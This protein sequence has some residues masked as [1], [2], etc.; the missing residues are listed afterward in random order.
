MQIKESELVEW[1]FM[2]N[3]KILYCIQY[4]VFI[5]GDFYWFDYIGPIL[6]AYTTIG[7]ILYVL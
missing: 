1:K 4:Q 3:N 2:L 6:L 7:L 5:N